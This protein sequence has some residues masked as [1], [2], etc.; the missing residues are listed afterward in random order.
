[1]QDVVAPGL[2][3][4]AAGPHEAD[5]LGHGRLEVDRHVDRGGG[6]ALQGEGEPPEAGQPHQLIDAG[7]H[8]AQGAAG[9]GHGLADAPGVPRDGDA[10]VAGLV[11]HS[12]LRL[13]VRRGPAPRPRGDWGPVLVRLGLV[14]RR[15]QPVPSAFPTS[16]TFHWRTSSS[17]PAG[18]SGDL[19]MASTAMSDLRDGLSDRRSSANS[20]TV[21]PVYSSANSACPSVISSGSNLTSLVCSSVMP[22]PSS[23]APG[24]E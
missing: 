6:A 24:R 17:A 21:L 15:R 13:V 19:A 23:Q 8:H 3:L 4:L 2:H 1:V 20:S 10:Y 14:P 18:S 11:G 7:L 22:S 16:V 9:L 12:A 5:E